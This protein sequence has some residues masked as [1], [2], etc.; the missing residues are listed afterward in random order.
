MPRFRTGSPYDDAFTSAAERLFRAIAASETRRPAAA[1]APP[2]LSSADAALVDAVRQGDLTAIAAAVTNG[3]DLNAGG[4][5]PLR[6]AAE[7]GKAALMQEL[8]LRGAE[9]SVAVAGLREEKKLAAPKSIR[10]D[11]PGVRAAL[12]ELIGA[13]APGSSPYGLSDRDVGALIDQIDQQ[14][15]QLSLPG[16]KRV[17]QIDATIAV[18]E[19]WQT[20]FLK[21]IAPLEILR[22]QR[23]ILEELADLKR[24]IAP[25]TLDKPKMKLPGQKPQPG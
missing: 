24:E 4:G 1:P 25:K 12:E 18:L 20:R 19:N 16:A 14:R 17:K 5:M 9:V 23:R 11:D 21:D 2:A 22:Q 7:T 3:A 10:R 13:L 8:V 15:G 6:V